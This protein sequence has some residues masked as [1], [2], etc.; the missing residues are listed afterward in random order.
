MRGEK[1]SEEESSKISEYL[2]LPEKRREWL[3]K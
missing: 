1:L 2:S 3:K